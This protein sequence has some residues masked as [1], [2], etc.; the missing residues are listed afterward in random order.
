MKTTIISSL[1]VALLIA[2]ATLSA[3]AYAPYE[4]DKTGYF[5]EHH[6]HHAFVYHNHHHGYWDSRGGTRIFINID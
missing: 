3:Q 2:G 1:T 6:H 4:H 5:D